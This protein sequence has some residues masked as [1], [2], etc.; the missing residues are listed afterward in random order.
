MGGVNAN[1]GGFHDQRNESRKEANGSKKR[2]S[3]P[4]EGCRILV[5]EEGM[6]QHQHSKQSEGG[7]RRKPGAI[8][9][10]GN[11]VSDIKFTRPPSNCSSPWGHQGQ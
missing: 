11:Q 8:Y 3:V 5:F 6:R 1:L 4:F 9:G 7:D 10:I 2:E